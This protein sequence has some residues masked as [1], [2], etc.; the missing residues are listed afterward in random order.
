MGSNPTV[1]KFFLIT[2]NTVKRIG[3]E[4]MD[5]S[6]HLGFSIQSFITIWATMA[7]WAKPIFYAKDSLIWSRTLGYFNMIYMND[8]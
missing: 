6:I 1:V 4:L 7:I 5:E 3:V 8:L 2:T